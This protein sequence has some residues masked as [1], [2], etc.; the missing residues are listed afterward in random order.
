MRAIAVCVALLASS[1]LAH[2]PSRDWT[3]IPEYRL[4]GNAGATIGPRPAQARER[5]R[6]IDQR[7][8]PLVFH[9]QEP[10]DRISDL[11]R[12]GELP[13]G[14]F[15][16]ELE[17][18]DHVNQPIGMILAARSDR[19]IEWSVSYFN[20]E[21]RLDTPRGTVS[22]SV[23]RKGFKRYWHH[24]V[25]VREDDELRLFIDGAHVGSVWPDGRPRWIEIASYMHNEPY[26]QLGNLVPRASLHHHAI[27]A[28]EVRMR[29]ARM[30]EAIENGWVFPGM[31]HFNAGPYLNS[32]QPTSM[33][34]VWGTD[35]PASARIEYGSTLPLD[36]AITIDEPRLIQEAVLNGL[37][38][39]TP[40]YYRVVAIDESGNEIE[41]GV[42]TFRTAGLPGDA[43][44]FAI[45]GDT[46]SRP[47]I[48][49][50]VAKLVWD[51][52]PEFVIN[53]GDLTD[54][55]KQDNLFQWTHEYFLGLNQLHSRIPAVPV[56]GNGEG[57]LYWYNRYH[58]LP[59]PEGYY[60]LRYGDI[61]L[62]MLDSNRR[63]SEFAPGGTQRVWL[64]RS[65]ADSD[66]KWK[67]AAHH[68]AVYSSDENDYGDTWAGQAS[69]L[70]DPQVQPLVEAYEA[71]GVDLVL[72]GHLHTYERSL[73]VRDGLIDT[74]RG[75]TY[76]QAGGAG[77]NLEDFTPTRTWF[78]GASHRGHHFLIVTVAGD[79]M[80]IKVYDIE[81]DLRDVFTIE[82]ADRSDAASP[83]ISGAGSAGA[84]GSE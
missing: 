77:G 63:G 44:R 18:V 31:F 48:N 42:L 57:D 29:L 32:P 16:F 39:A 19:E 24:V 6:V 64:E 25:V 41:S 82:A 67:I 61:E 3:F 59:A 55:G 47:H 21:I 52:R 66:A 45:I 46:E 62:F 11:V 80:Q 4:P 74:A 43:V 27:S 60:R 20:G 23:H 34:V 50:Q 56:A 69:T 84:E 76:I 37:K 35:R 51:H 49:D 2:G 79:E 75:V 9:G 33:A 70:G 54:G 13:D 38:P 53:V 78:S 28:D 8:A 10:T 15:A 5:L 65:L 14:D 22:A 71:G 36:R 7:P 83:R 72:Y 26:M 12:P 40:Y 17:L 81:G 30:H 68:H 1:V 58:A 73:P